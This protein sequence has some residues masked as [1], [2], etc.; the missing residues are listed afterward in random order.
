MTE[1]VEVS[2]AVVIDQ[3]KVLVQT[4]PEGADYAGFWEFPGGK[5]EAGE[6][7]ARCAEREC[8][9]ELGL[10]VQAKDLMEEVDWDYPGRR[11]AVSFY[12]CVLADSILPEDLSPRDGQR[13][14]WVDGQALGQLNFL[15]ANKALLQRL[16]KELDSPAKG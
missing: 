1:K 8:V 14:L 16:I 2:V 6:D 10:K 13:A 12:R 3:E 9:E 15:P 5:V 11:V 7:P 4:R